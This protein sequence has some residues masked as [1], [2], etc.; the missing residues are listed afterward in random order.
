MPILWLRASEPEAVIPDLLCYTPHF[1]LC[2]RVIPGWPFCSSGFNSG[3]CHCS[4][5]VQHRERG[6]SFAAF[7]GHGDA[8]EIRMLQYR[9]RAEPFAAMFMSLKDLKKVLLLQY[10]E[11]A[12]P[13]AASGE[14]FF[15]DL[16]QG[17]LQYR[18][19]AEPF[20]A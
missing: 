18:E 20:A 6:E 5:S 13:F 1:F 16:N 10:R 2:I 14:G 3:S 11:R 17:W 19:R 7:D 9:E 4:S 12:E 15:Q 8:S